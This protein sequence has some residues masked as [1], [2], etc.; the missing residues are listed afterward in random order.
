MCFSYIN[1][2]IPLGTSFIKLMKCFCN[3][4]AAGLDEFFYEYFGYGVLRDG[5][6]VQIKGV[7]LIT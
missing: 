4:N 7:K 5:F 3:T 2:N 1:D 6:V